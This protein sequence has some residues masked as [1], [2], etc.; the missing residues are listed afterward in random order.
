MATS[1]KIERTQAL[2][3]A[4]G[5]QGGTIHQVAEE[6]GCSVADLL[7]AETISHSFSHSQGWFAG[8]TCSTQF[9]KDVNFPNHK[10]D[11][12]FWHGVADGLVV[13]MREVSNG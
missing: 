2:C 7:Y 12:Q 5:W 11:V 1:S 4:L 3:N 13:R 6:T 10:G 9:N 8:R